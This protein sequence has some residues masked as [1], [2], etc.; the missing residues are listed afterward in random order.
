M[1]FNPTQDKIAI[2]IP[3][4]TLKKPSLGQGIDPLFEIWP[5]GVFN[6]PYF[7]SLAIDSYGIKQKSLEF[8]FTEYPNVRAGETVTMLGDGSLV[9]GP[10]NPGAFV[11][12]S[13]AFLEMDQDVRDA[14]KFIQ[15]AISSKAAELGLK[16][17]L[18]TNPGAGVVATF[19][20]ELIRFVA[21]SVADNKDDFLLRTEGVFLRDTS[22]PYCV[23]RSFQRS[24]EFLDMSLQVIPLSQPNG[25]GPE[26]QIVHL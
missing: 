18:A 3:Q 13:V 23:N 20:K 8:N 19:L 17:L 26:T 4:F 10:K 12:V 6:E 25:Q 9:Y 14:G 2:T 24:N 16:A 15:H 11:A 1:T 5:D 21:A 7:I 22:V